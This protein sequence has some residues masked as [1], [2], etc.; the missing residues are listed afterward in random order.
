MRRTTLRLVAPL[1]ALMIP[2]V[3]LVSLG[4][5]Y[6]NLVETDRR[7]YLLKRANLLLEGQENELSRRIEEIADQVLAQLPWPEEVKGGQAPRREELRTEFIEALQKGE[8]SPYATGLF[9][10]EQWRGFGRIIHPR[11]G[12]I[13]VLGLDNAE[14]PF[15]ALPPPH[16]T[17]WLHVSAAVDTYLQIPAFD[18]ALEAIAGERKKAEDRDLRAFLDYLEATVLRQQGQREEARKHFL[19]LAGRLENRRVFQRPQR[20]ILLCRLE[21]ALLASPEKR[22]E[23]LLALAE[24][25]GRGLWS[26]TPEAFLQF[27]FH[28]KIMPALEE[29]PEK[30]TDREVL[31]AIQATEEKRE[32]RRRFQILLYSA[33]SRIF[34]EVERNR[35]EDPESTLFLHQT[36]GGEP[37]VLAFRTH[38][39]GNRTYV[40]G[41]SLSLQKVAADHLRVLTLDS[42]REEGLI[43]SL[44]TPRNEPV[45]PTHTEGTEKSPPL[46]IRNLDTPLEGFR[47]QVNRENPEAEMIRVSSNR[48]KLGLYLAGLG[49]MAGTGAFLLMRTVRRELELARMKSDF[50]SR[51]THDLKTPLALIRL[52]GETLSLGRAANPAKVEEYGRIITDECDNLTGMIDKVLAFSR[53]ERGLSAYN[54]REGAIH[55]EVE[56]IVERFRPAA[57]QRRTKLEARIE[58]TE[59]VRI[60]REGLRRALLNLLDNAAKFG[61][62]S[63]LVALRQEGEKVVLEVSDRGK[64][65]PEEER[66]AVFTP[67]RRGRGA[68]EKRGSG[69]GLA[70][71]RHFTRAHG[72]SVR[73]LPREG[74]G[75]TMRMILPTVKTQDIQPDR[76]R[77]AGHEKE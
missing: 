50:I 31:E 39:N 73:A 72:G 48:M 55:E 71:V 43:I 18:W 42:R 65:I 49:L 69:L 53:I 77:S 37:L 62:G 3:L 2:L 9:L 33:K 57:A 10:L 26:N 16:Q 27:L 5:E 28:Q 17:R 41:V 36:Q 22:R 56:D 70:L 44:R 68:S 75:T 38:R 14:F 21:A 6:M 63:I 59:A 76:N 30:E 34:R 15:E 58:E 7:R 12:R 45:L 64:G 11:P 29:Y 23:E 47:L 52:Y 66:E 51:V 13:T 1:L 40:A 25:I 19:A 8:E 60:D 4:I 74:G 35:T 24:S 54:P 20:E 67:F 46:A 61:G 32:A